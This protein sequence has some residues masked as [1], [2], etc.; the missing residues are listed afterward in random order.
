MIKVLFFARIRDELG[1]AEMKVEMPEGVH[2]LAGFTRALIMANPSFEPALT[3]PNVLT[4]VNQEMAT[5]VTTI[6]D[7]DEIAYFPP[8]TGG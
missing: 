4:A 7:G 3:Q 8:V 5:P 2:D 6:E 1:R